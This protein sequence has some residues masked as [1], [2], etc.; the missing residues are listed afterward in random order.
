V[1][2]GE[3]LDLPEGQP[4]NFGAKA[5]AAHAKKQSVLELG[6]LCVGGDSFQRIEVGELLG[7]DIQPAEPVVLVGS[8]PNGGVVL[9]EALYFVIRFP[10]FERRLDGARE[11][12]WE[13]VTLAI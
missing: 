6:F 11:C 9:P 8:G 12:G 4:Q 7:S 5:R 2:L 13:L 3:T 1:K 10:I